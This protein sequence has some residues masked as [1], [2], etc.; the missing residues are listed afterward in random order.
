MTGVAAPQFKGIED[1]VSSSP[2]SQRNADS[3]VIARTA[4]STSMRPSVYSTSPE[5]TTAF[6][7][8][9]VTTPRSES[10]LAGTMENFVM[11]NQS[12][13]L[14]P[15]KSN[16]FPYTTT[17]PSR[18]AVLQSQLPPSSAIRVLFHEDDKTVTSSPPDYQS[19]IIIE[20][21]DEQ[22]GMAHHQRPLPVPRRHSVRAA[23]ERSSQYAA[24][25]RASGHSQY[26]DHPDSGQLPGL[27][28][29]YFD[30][31]DTPPSPLSRSGSRPSYAPGRPAHFDVP[32]DKTNDFDFS[33]LLPRP[34]LNE[35]PDRET[36][37]FE[38]KSDSCVCPLE[39]TLDSIKKNRTILT[40]IS[41][42]L[43][44]ASLP[45]TVS[46]WWKIPAGIFWCGFAVG[47]VG[48]ALFCLKARR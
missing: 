10:A 46:L 8:K 11:D 21:P 15:A 25:V 1:A 12:V 4:T 6:T 44:P 40:Q 47:L 17:S 31:P 22:T 36:S 38:A 19:L 7:T 18:S 39:E 29:H 42:D 41:D 3:T 23:A 45:C 2:A 37:P 33:S 30:V 16:S 13:S 14:P 48:L 43:H 27:P 26:P 35:T 9:P 20:M 34:G 24:L 32:L 28:Q 5:V